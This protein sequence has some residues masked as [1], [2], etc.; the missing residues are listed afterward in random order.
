MRVKL[1]SVFRYIA[2]HEA[3]GALLAALLAIGGA[4]VLASSVQKRLDDRDFDRDEVQQKIKLV[5][6]IA[7]EAARS[8]GDVYWRGQE[9]LQIE[10]WRLKQQTVPGRQELDQQAIDTR[11]GL[12]ASMAEWRASA[13]GW[14]AAMRFMDAPDGV[15]AG[16]AVAAWQHVEQV[17]EDYIQC[18]VAASSTTLPTEGHPALP[19]AG[20]V[21]AASAGPIVSPPLACSEYSI[22]IDGEVDDWVSVLLDQTWCLRE[23]LLREKVPSC[24]RPLDADLPGEPRDC[25]FQRTGLLPYF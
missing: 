19:P 1:P 25:R 13:R 8:A 18:V 11:K 6:S 7:S 22:T 4:F 24:C 23:W 9:V 3:V 10:A 16:D 15:V 2:E 12:N 21:V 20:E 14:S 5:Y 17:V